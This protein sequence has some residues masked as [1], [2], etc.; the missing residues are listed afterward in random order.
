MSPRR[1]AGLGLGLLASA[2]APAPTLG[3]DAPPIAHVWVS[4]CG[5]CHARVEPG[6]H[7]RSELTEALSA[8]RK[9]MRLSEA[10]WA[11]M[12]DFLARKE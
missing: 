8:H 4:Q 7:T 9:R 11:Q 12:V 1:L 3:P 10:E 6:S 2:C 5:R